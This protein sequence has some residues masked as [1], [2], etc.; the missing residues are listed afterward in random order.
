MAS[1]ILIV[2]DHAGFRT[3]ARALLEAGGYEVVGEAGDGGSAITAVREL[4]PQV[5]LLDVQLP[6]RDGFSVADELGR[7][8]GAPRIVFISSREAADYGTRLARRRG[9]G[10]I[11][12]PE[13]SSRRLAEL[14]GTPD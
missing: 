10:F 1:R 11:H 3:Q 7:G 14:V 6:D 2:D 12:K 13:L 5:V 9:D 8:N 4:H